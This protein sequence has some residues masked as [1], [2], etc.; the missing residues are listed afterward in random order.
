MELGLAQRL[1]RT[2]QISDWVQI[3]RVSAFPS[4]IDDELRSTKQQ[5]EYCLIVRHL[6]VVEMEK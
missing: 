5:C 6:H 4:H 3:P 1:H 2:D